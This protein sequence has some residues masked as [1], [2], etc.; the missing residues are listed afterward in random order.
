MLYVNV[1]SDNGIKQNESAEETE[2]QFLL[3]LHILT[4]RFLHRLS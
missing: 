3:L 2:H 1:D 4:K